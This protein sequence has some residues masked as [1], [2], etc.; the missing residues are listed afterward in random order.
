MARD[1]GFHPVRITRIVD[2]T[3]DVRT[4]TLDARFPYRAGQF[5]TFK[6]CGTLRSYSM[7]SSPDT[8]GE[9]RVTVKRVA[10]GLVSG[11]MHT[12]LRPG[13]VLEATRPTGSFCLREDATRR[14][15]VAY[16]GGSGITPVF[17]LVK[18]ALA[19]TDRPV[20]LLSAHQNAGA[21]IFREALD[22]LAERHADQLRLRH[23]LD[24]RDGLVTEDEIRALADGHADEADFYLCGPEP[25]MALVENT[26]T[27][28]GVAAE[29]IFVERFAPAEPDDAPSRPADGTVAPDRPADGTVTVDLRGRR[30]TVPQRHG[31]TL[32]QSARRAG[33]TPPFS[34]ESG[35]CATCMA[36]LTDGEAKMRVNNALD[37]DEVDEGW[38]LTCQAEPTTPEV[39]VV[40]ED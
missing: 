18:S 34:C 2:E 4:F 29:R 39:T 3:P 25:F 7:S 31:E 37:P 6:V 12:E 13:D 8:D 27:A 10:G 24:D 20:M 36:R 40:Y 23:H 9:I 26:L 5:L 28:H 16:A 19:T 15:L 17:S 30:R 14:P 33:F 21:A 32:L 35:D 11:W 38:V 22:A 1:H